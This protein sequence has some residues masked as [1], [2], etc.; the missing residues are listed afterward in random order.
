MLKKVEEIILTT[1]FYCDGYIEENKIV[2]TV[3]NFEQ[4]KVNVKKS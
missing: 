1:E 4:E 2:V 3:E